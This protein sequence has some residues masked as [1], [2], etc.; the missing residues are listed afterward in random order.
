MEIFSQAIQRVL[1]EDDEDDMMGVLTQ[2]ILTTVKHAEAVI[3]EE[4]C[5]QSPES[6]SQS[7][8]TGGFEEMPDGELQDHLSSVLLHQQ[9]C[10]TL[11]D[12]LSMMMVMGKGNGFARTQIVS[13]V[14]QQARFVN[15]ILETSEITWKQARSGKFLRPFHSLLKL[16]HPTT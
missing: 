6:Q 12:T 2:D 16:R 1:K 10:E 5:R 11:R 15:Q 7:F 4:Q 13:Y 14:A 3:R 9:E 8:E